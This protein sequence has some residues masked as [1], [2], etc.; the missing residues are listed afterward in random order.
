MTAAELSLKIAEFLEPK[1]VLSIGEILDCGMADTPMY[2]KP[3]D[4]LAGE[5]Q[6]RDMVND[7]AMTVMLIEKLRP[8]AISA[9]DDSTNVMYRRDNMPHWT[10][11]IKTLGRAVA[12]AFAKAKG[13]I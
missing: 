10:G 2:W 5:W 1:P 13:L 7:P 11:E 6:P 3:H 8:C 12:E 9:L 4:E